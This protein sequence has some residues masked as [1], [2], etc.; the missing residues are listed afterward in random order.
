[1]LKFIKYPAI[2]RGVVVDNND[3]G[4]LEDGSET[5]I[6]GRCKIFVD[7]VY[8]DE[9]REDSA[10]MLPWAEP[11]FPIFGGN[12]TTAEE[13][14]ADAES[15]IQPIKNYTNSLVGWASV[16]HIGAT[17]WVFFENGNIQYPKYFGMTQ[18]GNK[19]LSEHKNQHV[20]ATD[21]V[22]III[23]E[24]PENQQSTARSESNNNESTATVAMM[25][26][27][28]ELNKSNM[29][30]RV[31]ITV[32]CNKPEGGQENETNYCA[33]NLN[34]IGN[35]NSHIQGNVYQQIDGDRFITVNG[36]QYIRYN[37]DIEIEHK[38][39]L[40]ETH[41]GK[42]DFM[43]TDGDNTEKYTQNFSSSVVGNSTYEIGGNRS[44]TIG[45]NETREASGNMTDKGAMINHN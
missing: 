20:I 45:G 35:V 5:H 30:T 38:G 4:M 43:V 22:K 19:Y 23:D 3:D 26:D 2:Y 36:N 17:V 10:K 13:E 37:G 44:V 34:I 31:N 16:P 9:F 39:L 28:A 6:F 18:T 1:M 33:V 21:N 12:S 25:G 41:Y 32:V 7:G 40:K 14:E 29:P 42:R 27:S 15:E 8:P 24:E 11:V